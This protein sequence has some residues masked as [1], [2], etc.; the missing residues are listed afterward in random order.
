VRQV[1]AGFP[2]ISILSFKP[3]LA[4]IV[5]IAVL[6]AAP[7]NASAASS[8]YAAIVIDANTGK[9]LFSANADTPRYPASLTKMMTLY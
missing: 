8:K 9:T 4:G 2:T 3:L 1:W 6:L 5:A 7:M